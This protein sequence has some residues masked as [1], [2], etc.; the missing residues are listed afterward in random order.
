M[1]ENLYIIREL[2]K[3][4]ETVKIG[5]RYQITIPK[6][7]RKKW[8]IREGDEVFLVQERDKLS[9]IPKVRDP[10]GEASQLFGKAS[11]DEEIYASLDQEFLPEYWRKRY[12]KS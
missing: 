2:I 9:I 10:L 1:S 6:K 7:I 11:D 5:K 4:T 8:K 3:M 12:A